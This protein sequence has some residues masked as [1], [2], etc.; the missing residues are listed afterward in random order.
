[1]FY[2]A[3]RQDRALLNFKKNNVRDTKANSTIY[4]VFLL[5]RPGE[6]YL[7]PVW[8]LWEPGKLLRKTYPASAKLPGEA[9]YQG[10]VNLMHSGNPS[11]N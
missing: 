11:K 3:N 8:S 10:T 5:P 9:K 4:N 6:T 2:H 1:M 7:G